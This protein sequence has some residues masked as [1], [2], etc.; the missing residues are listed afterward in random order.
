MKM[1]EL[2]P[3]SQIQK[4]DKKAIPCT[5]MLYT[6]SGTPIPRG[7]N[8]LVG[9]K[10]E[11]TKVEFS[12]PRRKAE[13]IDLIESPPKS[14]PTTSGSSTTQKSKTPKPSTG[15]LNLQ[16]ELENIFPDFAAS[17]Q[18]VIMKHK[19]TSAAYNVSRRLIKLHGELIKN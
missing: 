13:I 5:P 12:L 14:C 16:A 6:C 19:G 3:F 10:R 8:D 18:K 7:K 11:E 2:L 9:V 17:V 15:S 4:S 1:K